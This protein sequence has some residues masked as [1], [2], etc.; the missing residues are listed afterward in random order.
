MICYDERDDMELLLKKIK[1]LVK[2]VTFA[3]K[4]R[5]MIKIPVTVYLIGNRAGS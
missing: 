5:S 1:I 2:K 4:V 3:I